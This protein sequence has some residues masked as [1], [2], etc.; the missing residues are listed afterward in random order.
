[1]TPP[2]TAVSTDAIQQADQ[3]FNSK[4][5]IKALVLYSQVLHTIQ[6]AD[7]DTIERVLIL[8]S[9]KN[10]VQLC[11][12]YLRDM[13]TIHTHLGCILYHLQRMDEEMVSD[14]LNDAFTYQ[15]MKKEEFIHKLSLAFHQFKEKGNTYLDRSEGFCNA[16]ICNYKKSGF[17]FKGD[18]TEHYMALIFEVKDEQVVD[19]YEC[20]NFKCKE[21][22][23]KKQF[24]IY[25]DEKEEDLPF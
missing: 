2:N 3:F 23:L 24:Q 4:E 25:V 12:W 9:L 11:K 16:Q 1:M 7:L 8:S 17:L 22:V 5:F 18:T 6:N 14:L 20:S 19:I 15:E 21:V 13:Q 10:K